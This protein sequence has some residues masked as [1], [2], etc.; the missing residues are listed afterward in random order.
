MEWE[1]EQWI[2]EYGG[3]ESISEI[4]RRHG[5]SRKTLYK[6]IERHEAA[7][8]AGLED[9]SRVPHR[10][11]QAV[12]ELWRERIRAARQ[13]HRRW[14]A[15]KLA[16]LLGQK[17]PQESIP[18]VSTLG[19]VLR[20][21]G[22]SRPRRRNR[23]HGTG[24]LEP[25]AEANQVWAIDFKGWCRTGDGARCEPLTITDQ[26][27]RYLLCCQ[28]LPSNTGTWVRA[29]M[30]TI[31]ERYGLPER[32]LSD[33]GSPFASRSEYGLTRLSVWWL[34]LGIDCER[35]D[36]G[37]PQQNGRHERMHRTL[38]EATMQP[39]AATL[40]QQQKRMDLFRKEFNEE[41]PHQALGQQ[42]PASRYRPS[43]RS[44]SRR[45]IAPDYPRDWPQR[46]VF[47]GGQFPWHSHRVF[48]SHALENKRVGFEPVEDG[49]WRV[50]FYRLWL[51]MWEERSLR[52]WRPRDWERQRARRSASPGSAAGFLA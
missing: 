33:N 44:Y 48:V 38:A 21:S 34:E 7:G 5:I 23:V 40:R 37:R 39:P 41:R 22:L 15:P 16:W 2:A 1:R 42:V 43:P 45:V 27:S 35:I 29:A 30:E 49:L 9:L 6:W 52:L 14:G 25:A 12:S 10:H 3:G 32:I 46:T 47:G 51:G 18:S 11:P 26:A 4:A 36:P 28:A 8:P 50:W 13:E 19:R 24:A 20:D 17:Y 31:F